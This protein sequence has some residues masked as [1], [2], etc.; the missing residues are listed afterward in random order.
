MYVD[1]GTPDKLPDGG[2]GSDFEFIDMS[3]REFITNLQKQDGSNPPFYYFTSTLD[4]FLPGLSDS[5]CSGWPDLIVDPIGA[6]VSSLAS[7]PYPS[8]WM[9]G[10][11]STTQAHY[12]VSHNVFTQVSGRKRI[13]LWGP[14]EHMALRVFPDAHPRARKAQISIVPTEV[15]SFPSEIETKNDLTPTPHMDVTLLPGDSMYCTSLRKHQAYF[16]VTS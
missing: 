11:G 6:A 14:G 9:G 16:N 10:K 5:V 8:L 15:A 7:P 4:D 1:P 3:A 2:I 12:D 13:R